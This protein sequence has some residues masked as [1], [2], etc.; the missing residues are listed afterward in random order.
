MLISPLT[1]VT[2]PFNGDTGTFEYVLHSE[3]LRLGA[4]VSAVM[5]SQALKIRPFYKIS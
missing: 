1:R 2:V 4:W 3:K 5:N